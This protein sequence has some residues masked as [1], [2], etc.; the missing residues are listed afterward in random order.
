[1]SPALRSRRGHTDRIS[2]VT[3][4]LIGVVVVLVASYLIFTKNVPIVHGYRV[5]GVFASSNQLRKGSPVRIAGV[6]VGKVV[7]FEDG[8]G[9]TRVVVMEIKKNG[10]PIHTDARLRIRPRLFLEGGFYVQLSPGSPSAPEINENGTIPLSHTTIPVQ[11]NQVLTAL[12]RPT[13]ESLSGLV[14]ELSTATGNGG[15]EAL[16]ATPRPIKGALKDAAILFEAAR[17]TREHDVSTGI[18]STARITGAL[19]SRDTEL[20]SLVVNLDRTTRALS[21][22]GASLSAGIRELDGTLRVAP[23]ALTSLDR[24]L[25]P[26]R[27]FSVALRPSF[28]V[29]P[30][31]LRDVDALLAQTRGLVRPSELPLLVRRLRPVL[32]S[33][34]G[35]QSRLTA[36]FPLVTPVTECV[37][38][39][40]IPV[41]DAKVDDG[42]LS[43]NR[44]VWQELSQLFV[45][46][47]GAGSNFDANGTFVRYLANLGE[48]TIS[49]GSLSGLGQI[50]GTSSGTILGAR[51]TY[52]GN[53]VTPPFNSTA[54]C[55]DQ[56]P[57]DLKA[58][59]SGT[60]AATRQVKGGA[61]GRTVTWS[62]LTKVLRAPKIGGSR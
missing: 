33:L 13:R 53:G 7:G 57:P 3:L 47:A 52:L 8:P 43:S 23:S 62:R 6:D 37:D 25:P 56:T 28:Q 55:I 38:K 49:T 18:A 5:K 11:F 46:L 60:L 27:R 1:M 40:A 54:R 45:G 50:V 2:P 58:R 17:G 31:V 26:L 10:R 32:A 19:A 61:P 15:A 42:A 44:P 30:G 39:R 48:N 29:A 4:G 34:P 22:E 20:A 51:P 21:T 36:L 24:T 35:L 14:G 16:A 9:T 59:T 41:L 12:D